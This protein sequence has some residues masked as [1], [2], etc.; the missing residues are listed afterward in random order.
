MHL[1]A[2]DSQTFGLDLGA[3]SLGIPPVAYVVSTLEAEDDGTVT[4]DLYSVLQMFSGKTPRA[5]GIA[6]G[7]PHRVPVTLDLE[8]DVIERISVSPDQLVGAIG[9]AGLDLGPLADFRDDLAVTAQLKEYGEDV[10]VV[11]PPREFTIGVTDQEQ[12]EQDRLECDQRLAD[13]S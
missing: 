11:R 4:S 8:D 9:D 6:P 5:L 12:L 13:A 2:E 7:S 3:G 1:T 10:D